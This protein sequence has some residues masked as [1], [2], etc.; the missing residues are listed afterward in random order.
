MIAVWMLYGALWTLWLSCVAILV[1]RIMLGA[2]GPV[3]IVWFGAIVLS[4]F[5]PV[6]A[7]TASRLKPPPT[8]PVMNVIAPTHAMRAPVQLPSVRPVVTPIPSAVSAAPATT[9]PSI[10]ARADRPLLVAWIVLSLGLCA[11]F[12]GGILRLGI[13]RRGWRSKNINGESVLLSDDTGPALVGFVDPAIVIPA[14]AL[15]LD[16]A[17]L[18]LMLRHEVEHRRAGDTRVLTLAQMLVVLMPWNVALWWQ[19]RRLRL[20]IE[21]DCDA[22]VLAGTA[23]VGA[24]GRLLLEFGR[25]RRAVQFAGAAL[26]DHPTDLETRI[27]RMTNRARRPRRRALAGSVIAGVVAI[28]VGCQLPAPPAPAPSTPRESRGSVVASADSAPKSSVRDTAERPRASADSSKTSR[29]EVRAAM[30]DSSTR[31][32]VARIIAVTDS[33]ERAARLL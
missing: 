15:S 17:A 7:G 31:T 22:R 12:A 16:A 9:L 3:R 4:L 26:V 32:D 1:E 2:R 14:W 28:V 25:A 11:Y 23:D 29:P 27:R 24:Y 20:A 30:R 19:L 33:V 10:A 21:L 13:L 6:A 18:A 8:A 5:A